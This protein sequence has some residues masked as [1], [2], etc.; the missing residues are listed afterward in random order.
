MTD[1]YETLQEMRWAADCRAAHNMRKGAG[2][3]FAAALADAYFAADSHNKDRLLA[4]FR[5]IFDRF[6]TFEETT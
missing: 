1:I 2:G 3:S 5:D 6:A 4:T